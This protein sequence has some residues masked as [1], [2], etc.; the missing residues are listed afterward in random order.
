VDSLDETYVKPFD[1]D[2]CAFGRHE[3]FPLRYSWLTKGFHELRRDPHL[4]EAEDVTV[5]LGVGKNMV[6]AIRYWL[7]AAGL[8][9]RQ[10]NS[11]VPTDLGIHVFDPDGYDPYLEDEATIWLVHWLLASNAQLATAWYWFFNY[12]HK[13]EF[14]GQE[15]ATALADFSK[16]NVNGRNSVKTIK[17]DANILLRMYSR[18]R[19]T[20]RTPLE[21]ALD[22]PLAL[23]GLVHHEGAGKT[24]RSLAQ[25]REVP[26]GII[27]F[28]TVDLCNAMQVPQIPIAQLMYGEG[29]WPALG[30]V[31]RLTEE[32]LLAKLELLVREMPGA[33]AIRETAGIHQF[34]LLEDID[35]LSLLASQYSD[36]IREAVA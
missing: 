5:R 22:S 1:P 36:D 26:V 20:A 29:R 18:S 33:F 4:F 17:Q 9:E 25:R 13:P 32:A 14:T 21:E 19:V 11:Y 2:R 10:A 30:A 31:F 7:Q 16:N 15:V 34:Y 12:F 35:P 23:L 6:N 3:T 8:V 27:A 24:Y 28:A